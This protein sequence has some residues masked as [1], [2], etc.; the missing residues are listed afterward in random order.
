MY[1]AL[2]SVEELDITLFHRL[3]RVVPSV[4]LEEQYRM[5]SKL[6]KFPSS[7]FYGGKLVCSPSIENRLP[8]FDLRSYNPVDFIDVVSSRE[9]HE[10]TSFRNEQEANVVVTVVNFLITCNVSPLEITVL[11]PYRKQVQCLIEKLSKSVSKVEVCTIDNFQGKE[12]DVV[13]FSTVRSNP[14]GDLNFIAKRNRINVLLTRAKHCVIGVGHKATLEKLDLWKEWL[15]EANVLSS[16]CQYLERICV[17]SSNPKSA[18]V[19]TYPQGSGSSDFHKP[20]ETPQRKDH[21]TGGRQSKSQARSLCQKHRQSSAKCASSSSDYE[22]SHGSAD[23]AS[24]SR[25]QFQSSRRQGAGYGRRDYTSEQGNE[26]SR[27]PEGDN[28]QRAHSDDRSHHHG[29]VSRYSNGQSSDRSQHRNSGQASADRS[30]RASNRSQPHCTPSQ[31]R[32]H[33]SATVE[34]ASHH[35]CGSS[36]DHSNC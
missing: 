20:R 2:P 28:H 11:T 35:H 33:H 30:H 3:Q 9:D 4:V 32:D 22:R 8:N 15:Q 18:K 19:N 24:Q 16:D 1:R 14:L 13:I 25:S 17:C 7:K 21:S 5:S 36:S 31:S 10:G 29:D 26:L 6:V 27:Y 23:G 12:N 34:Q